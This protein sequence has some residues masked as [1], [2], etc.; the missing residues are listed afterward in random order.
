MPI[1]HLS[2][3]NGFG[4][5][6][7]QYI[8]RIIDFLASEMSKTNL[9]TLIVPKLPTILLERNLE[10]SSY[11]SRNRQGGVVHAILRV[12][13]STGVTASTCMHICMYK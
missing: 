10:V 4:C 6:L 13:L 12:Q 2:L 9:E 1:T 3:G 5:L 11:T 8:N 7:S